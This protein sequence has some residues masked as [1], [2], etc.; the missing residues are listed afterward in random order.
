M[1]NPSPRSQ[2]GRGQ[3]HKRLLWYRC[4]ILKPGAAQSGASALSHFRRSGFFSVLLDRPQ[5]GLDLRALGLQ[6]W[7]Q[8]ESF[9]QRFE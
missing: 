8:R 5:T 7:R 4:P 1:K 3:R 6:E 2:V 9:A